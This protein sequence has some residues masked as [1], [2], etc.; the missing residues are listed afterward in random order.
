VHKLDMIEA[1]LAEPGGASPDGFDALAREVAERIA[2]HFEEREP[3][4]MVM[5]FG[6]HG[7]AV[8]RQNEAFAARQGGASPEEV[9]VPAFAW[10]CGAV[11]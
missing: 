2:A 1:R 9:L 7:F 8:E 3:R 4:T 6:D 10:L 5:V 11:H